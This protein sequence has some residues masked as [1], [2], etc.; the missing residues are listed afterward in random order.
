M[1]IKSLLHD[2]VARLTSRTTHPI[3]SSAL[4]IAALAAAAASVGIADAAVRASAD[5]RPAEKSLADF[6]SGSTPSAPIRL[7]PAV[8]TWEGRDL[9]GDGRADIA[10]PTGRPPREVDA[11]GEGR[12]HASRDGGS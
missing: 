5:P 3:R 12:F 7:Q 8:V 9:D 2:A 10:D 1:P 4:L 6:P 11:Y